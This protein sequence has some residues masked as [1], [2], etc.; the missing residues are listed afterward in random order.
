MVNSG[1]KIFPPF[2]LIITYILLFVSV[3][4]LRFKQV[5]HEHKGSLLDGNFNFPK[6]L[7]HK[8]ISVD[9]KTVLK[10]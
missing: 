1:Q 4:Y 6:I 9:L 5:F 10:K 7:F 2:P 3:K 8:L